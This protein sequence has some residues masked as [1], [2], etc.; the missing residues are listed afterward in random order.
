MTE[1]TYQ[2]HTTFSMCA[3]VVIFSCS[4]RNPPTATTINDVLDVEDK[5]RLNFFGWF[6]HCL[7]VFP[8][9]CQQPMMV[10]IMTLNKLPHYRWCSKQAIKM[11]ANHID[12]RC[13]Q[14]VFW[15]QRSRPVFC[16]QVQG[17]RL[18]LRRW[19][20]F[21]TRS[22]YKSSYCFVWSTEMVC[23]TLI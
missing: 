4:H 3:I 19:W 2:Q 22:I 6:F 14:L 23:C 5:Y 11:H 1:Q 9:L 10:A 21:F 8:A 15:R 20:I 13:K 7:C 16:S 17:F 12:N 18:K